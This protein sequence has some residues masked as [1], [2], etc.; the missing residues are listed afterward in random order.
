MVGE[1][2]PRLSEEDRL[3]GLATATQ[4]QVATDRPPRAR[5]HWATL[6]KRVYSIDA[7]ACPCGGRLRF[8][9]LVAEPSP[10]SQILVAL[11]ICPTPP[12]RAPPR[13]SEWD[14]TDSP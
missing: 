1:P 5:A 6:L 10:I 9:A 8:V 12:A 11:G 4:R 14:W 13:Q 3:I 2:D 7:L